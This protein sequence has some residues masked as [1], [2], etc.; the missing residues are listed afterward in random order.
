VVIKHTDRMEKYKEM[1]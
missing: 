1:I